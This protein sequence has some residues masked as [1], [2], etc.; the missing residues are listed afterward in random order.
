MVSSV[1]N[2]KKFIPIHI[3]KQFKSLEAFNEWLERTKYA[4]IELLDFGQDL[5]KIYL[6]NNGSYNHAR[7]LILRKI[8]NTDDLKTYFE[9]ENI[10]VIPFKSYPKNYKRVILDSIEYAQWKFNQAKKQLE[11]VTFM[12]HFSPL[13]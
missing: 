10:S 9:E 6:A 13:I 5:T 7:E 11:R 4:T 3:N 12:K 1:N 8:L 2:N